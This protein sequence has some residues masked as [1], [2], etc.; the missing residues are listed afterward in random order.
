M[1]LADGAEEELVAPAPGTRARQPAQKRSRIRFQALLDSA[2]ELLKECDFGEVG[3]Y[4]IAQHASVPPASVYHFFPTKEAA[5]VA[6]A[7]RFFDTQSEILLQPSPEHGLLGWPDHLRVRYDRAVEF[8]NANPAFSRI[9]FSGSVTAE[10]R[11]I[12]VEFISTTKHSAYDWLSRYYVMPYLP[13][14]GL[15]F[16]VL[17][18]IYDGIWAASYARHGH[19]STAFRREALRAGIAYCRTF[20]PDV[21]PLRE[22][23]KPDR[24]PGPAPRGRQRNSEGK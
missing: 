21:L 17:V 11:R 15:K 13:D 12:D 20:L 9:M 18:G 8:Y 14:A 19:I 23:D 10:I 1:M 5:F 2:A 6:L 4:D 22:P 7:Q 3:L 24:A 16:T